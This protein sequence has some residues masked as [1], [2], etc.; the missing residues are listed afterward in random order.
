MQAAGNTSRIADIVSKPLNALLV[1]NAALTAAAAVIL[2]VSPGTIP[3]TVGF[4]TGRDTYPMGYMLAAAEVG[5]TVMFLYGRKIRDRGGLSL[6]LWAGIGFHV[7]SAL[8]Q[9]YALSQGQAGNA[10]G[11]NIAL[12]VLLASL[13]LFYAVRIRA[14]R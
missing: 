11:A 8:A 4:P 3:T 13:L 14:G 2:T 10:V 5:L 7:A 6:V 12:R 9:I 1:F